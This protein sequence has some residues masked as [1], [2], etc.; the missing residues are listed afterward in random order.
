VTPQGGKYFRL[1][2]RYEGKEKLLALGTYPE[3]SLAM[4]GNGEKKPDN[5]L[6]M[7]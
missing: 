7:A 4:P 5:S 6:P 1:K 2:Y 3:I